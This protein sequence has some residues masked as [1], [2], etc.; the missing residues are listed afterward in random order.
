MNRE[1]FCTRQCKALVILD[2][3][4]RATI[5]QPIDGLERKAIAATLRR[6]MDE[7]VNDTVRVHHANGW[8]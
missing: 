6:C 3:V 4:W 7:V 1:Q 2:R 5:L 8:R